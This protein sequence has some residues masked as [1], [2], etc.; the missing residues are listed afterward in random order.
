MK[1]KTI[2]ELLQNRVKKNSGKL[3]LQK[4]D[5][6]SWKQIT[7]LDFDRNIRNIAAYLLDLG[8]DVGNAVL[9][10]SSNRLESLYAE[11]AVYILGGVSI[12]IDQDEDIIEKLNVASDVGIKFIFI[13]DHSGLSR[14][15]NFS[16][17]ISNLK[18]IVVFS[19]K[20]YESDD[21]VINFKNLLKFGLMKKKQHEDDLREITGNVSPNNVA[22]IFYNLNSNGDV[23]KKE[24]TQQNLIE[25]I[26]RASEKL[27]I[28]DKEDQSY[29]YMPSVSPFEKF[30]NYLAIYMEFR[31]VLS[32]NR[33]DFYEEILE[34]KPTVIFETQSGL[35]E[36]IEKKLTNLERTSKG[37]TLKRELGSRVKYIITDSPPR[38]EIK[39]IFKSS[40]ISII[41]IPEFNKIVN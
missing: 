5:G 20:R 28:L 27:E 22:S 30:V 1:E 23:I 26:H 14:V 16:D 9:I 12:P 11:I 8:F 38:E 4:R 41:D 10:A 32:E 21:K 35:E 13:G 36:I 18:K 25:I 19:D 37:Q 29:S 7:W 33:E 15:I 40:N 34:V 2:N 39:D 24:I 31:M 6:W 17:K 3:L